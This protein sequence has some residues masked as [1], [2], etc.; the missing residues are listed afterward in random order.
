VSEYSCITTLLFF[1]GYTKWDISG[2]KNL[3]GL[4]KFVF[5][6][7]IAH[8]DFLVYAVLHLVLVVG[9]CSYALAGNDWRCIG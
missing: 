3:A 5:G 2:A 7:L 9:A 6:F 1:F 4:G 8:I